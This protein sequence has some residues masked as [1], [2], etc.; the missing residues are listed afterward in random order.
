MKK[1][2]VLYDI[3]LILIYNDIIYSIDNTKLWG[4]KEDHM[5]K[6]FSTYSQLLY[7]EHFLNVQYLHKYLII[8]RV[9]LT[10][11]E[12]PDYLVCLALKVKLL[13]K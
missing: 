4:S 11:P 8:S 7:C 5:C 2:I 6:N 9:S 10:T 1:Y 12:Q 3:E 13:F